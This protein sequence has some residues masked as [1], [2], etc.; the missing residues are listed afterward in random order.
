[1]ASPVIATGNGDT[2]NL[3][4]RTW[5]VYTYD[6]HSKT[7]VLSSDA[8]G[9]VLTFN[10]T[11]QR[12]AGSRAHAVSPPPR[13]P[14]PRQRLPSPPG[15]PGRGR[16]TWQGDTINDNNVPLANGERLGRQPDLPPTGRKTQPPTPGK[17]WR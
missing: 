12:Y 8:T 9:N 11:R 5:A 1:M 14:P 7:M 16:A 15:G 10:Y 17:S 3:L 13:Y 2:M 4:P 6:V